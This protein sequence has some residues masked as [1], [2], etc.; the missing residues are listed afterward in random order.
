MPRDCSSEKQTQA[1][2][3]LRFRLKDKHASVLKLKAFWVNQVW[4][5][6][7]DLSYQVW[8][9]ERRFM[10][11]YDFAQYT[12]GAGK[13]G[14]ALHSQTIQAISEEFAVRRRAAKKVKLNW[15]ASFGSRKA[16]G[17]IPFKASA[18]R[19]RNGQL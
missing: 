2:R 9:R 4:N 11:G 15:R 16:L 1:T 18:L 6:C 3:V 13:A 12:K 17:W 8:R 5:Y 14:I 7:N 19:Y 10:T